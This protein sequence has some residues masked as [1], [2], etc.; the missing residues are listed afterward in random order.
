MPAERWYTDQTIFIHN[1][2]SSEQSTADSSN[3]YSIMSICQIKAHLNKNKLF[4]RCYS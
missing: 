1:S 3:T 2:D 4:R